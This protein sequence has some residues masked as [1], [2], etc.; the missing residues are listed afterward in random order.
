MVERI[1]G[2]NL[3]LIEKKN[4]C[5]YQVVIFTVWGALE[6]VAECMQLLRIPW[7]H[8]CISISLFII[9][10]ATSLKLEKSKGRESELGKM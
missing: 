10:G 2:Q 5:S 1:L 4:E 7:S 6:K 3:V 8:L 9:F